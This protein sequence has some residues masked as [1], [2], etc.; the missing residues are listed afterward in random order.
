MTKSTVRPAHSA[1]GLRTP[2]HTACW[3][4]SRLLRDGAP[5]QRSRQASE[6]LLQ[7]AAGLPDAHLS[8]VFAGDGHG[9]V[10]IRLH[11]DTTAD[12]DQLL[13]WVFEDVAHW[14]RIDHGALLTAP[15]GMGSLVELVPA[16]QV[17]LPEPLQLVD[18]L[19]VDVATPPDLWPVGFLHDGMDLLTALTTMAAQVRVHIAP[20]SDLERQ[21]IAALTRKWASSRD[22]LE[23]SQYMGTPVRIRC[24]VGQRGPHLNPRLRA[25]LGGLGAGLQLVPR[26]P[27]DQSDLAD[28]DGEGESLTGAV[29]P[30]GVAMCFVHL[31]AAGE[32][33]EMCG[34]P[35][36]EAETRPV[37]LDT[38][39]TEE[40]L[41][42]GAAIA[43]DGRRRDVRL[44]RS[45]LTLHTQVLGAPG[46]GKSSLLAA[47]VSEAVAAGLGVSVLDP[48]GPLVERL[49]AERDESMI[50]RTVVVRSGDVNN[51]VPVNVLANTDPDLVSDVMLQV[52][53]ELHDPANQGYLGP[54]FE[55]AYA[56]TI[57]AMRALFG[58]RA[59][60]AA[61]PL[62]L[63]SQHDVRRLVGAL[64]TLDPELATQMQNEFGNIRSEDFAELSAWI[65]A[66][67]QRPVASPEMRAILLSGEDAVDVTRVID[68]R[69]LLLVDLASPSVGGQGAQFLG[70]MWLTKH[71]AALSQRRD[72]T[73]P[74]LLIVDEAHLFGSGLLPRL[75]AEGRKF[76]IAVVIAHQNLEQLTSELREAALSTTSNTIVFRSGPREAVTALT[77]L[78]TWPGGP[79]TR[80][81]R[82]HAAASLSQGDLQTDAFSLHVDHNDRADAQPQ[83]EWVKDA[84][85]AESYR[86]HVEPFRDSPPLTAEK[87]DARVEDVTSDTL[88]RPARGATSSRPRPSSNGAAS[89]LDQWLDQRRTRT[90]P[91]TGD[92]PAASPPTPS[93][94][95][96]PDEPP[97]DPMEPWNEA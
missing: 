43:S 74:H 29:Q 4:I 52:L 46:M 95:P 49:L 97:E 83:P 41:R 24:F 28:W 96:F 33:V 81:R 2:M 58:N 5:A 76:G 32:Q 78:G 86:R 84:I 72:R 25:A 47:L 68:D 15:D 93:E 12:M 36:A 56:Q 69:D 73:S 7:V 50:G 34:V 64:E 35:T 38:T 62:M 79:L 91:V 21:M 31:P 37:P 80:L 66:K 27:T 19:A 88:D 75:L 53:R 26:D 90:P 92:A 16:V 44:G 57:R 23:Y 30:F 48:H 8:L 51:P 11:S 70:E 45:D 1:S 14:H 94:P 10:Q 60:I 82:L 20:A 59:N 17:R 54:R 71:W 61:L 13:D 77:R 3:E 40:G 89:F 22:P 39:P 42:I 6:R 18:P 67:F 55:R 9:G 85:V 63:R 87:V 65:N